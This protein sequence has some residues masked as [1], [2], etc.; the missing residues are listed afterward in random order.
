MKTCNKCTRN[1]YRVKGWWTDAEVNF[2][3]GGCNM[4]EDSCE[5]PAPELA[6]APPIPNGWPVPPISL[7]H[8][9]EPLRE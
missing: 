1:T 5:C 2:V 4:D 3:C 9:D 8:D 6:E 7:E